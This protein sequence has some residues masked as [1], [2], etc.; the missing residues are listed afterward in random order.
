MMC[1]GRVRAAFEWA[2]ICNVLRFMMLV[3]GTRNRVVNCTIRNMSTL[4]R[5]HLI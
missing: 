5:M 4:G 2:Y 1:V 3:F